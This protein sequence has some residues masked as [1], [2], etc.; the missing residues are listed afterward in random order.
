M[1]FL[2]QVA[3]RIALAA[4][5]FQTGG[6]PAPATTVTA[7]EIALG[8]DAYA[9]MV[10]RGELLPHAPEAALLAPVARKLKAVADPLYG[11]PFTFYI[12]RSLVPNAFVIYGPRVYVDR[13]LIRLADS[14]EE[15]A[16]VLCHEISHAL[17]HDGTRDDSLEVRY[18]D[19]TKTIMARLEA[20]THEHF[21][22]HIE[23]FSSAAELFVWKHHS[24]AEEERADLAGADLCARAG[25]DPWG[26]VWMFEKIDKIAPSG[27][28]F[29][30]DHPSTRARIAA[31]KRHF[32]KNPAVF[33]RWSPNEAGATPLR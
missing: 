22:K 33:A 12:D 11:T 26:L 16:G 25:I 14:Q 20:A 3:V 24:R 27:P 32:R 23:S 2:R 19:R 9:Q 17:H 30:S 1:N 4:C 31:L 8:N 5:L 29:F 18:D 13:G 10:A 7:A 6:E 21:V 28:S 15:L